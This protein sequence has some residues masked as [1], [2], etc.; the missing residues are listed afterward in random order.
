MVSTI[1]VIRLSVKTP[2]TSATSVDAPRP[3]VASI[4]RMAILKSTKVKR[5]ISQP[6]VQVG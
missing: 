1:I 6:S 4:E 3:L 5:W 2:T